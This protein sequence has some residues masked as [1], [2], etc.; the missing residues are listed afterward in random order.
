MPTV[1]QI[2]EIINSLYNHPSFMVY[3]VGN[4]LRF[5]GK[6]PRVSEIREIIRREDPTR[7]FLDTCADGEYDRTTVDFDV[8]HMGYYFP[9]GRNNNMFS[10]TDNLLGFGTVRGIDMQTENESGTSRLCAAILPSF[11]TVFF[12]FSKRIRS[13]AAC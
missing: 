12:I 6:K 13:C 10:D 5:P 4:E 3:C 2:Y 11:S 8:Q 7:L 1:K 9:Y